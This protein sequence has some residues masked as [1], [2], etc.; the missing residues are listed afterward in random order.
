[1]EE[2]GLHLLGHRDRARG[3]G[4]SAAGA[5]PSATA[6][7]PRAR[8]LTFALAAPS[9]LQLGSAA[10]MGNAGVSG[11][12]MIPSAGHGPS[13][14]PLGSGAGYGQLLMSLGSSGLYGARAAM[15]P[16]TL[17]D[18]MGSAGDQLGQAFSKQ[19]KETN[20]EALREARARIAEELKNERAEAAE[21][22]AEADSKKR[23]Q[24][25][26]YR[27]ISDS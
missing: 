12:D 18:T 25:G 19:L 21:H 16:P 23:D 24:E 15:Y 7:G 5:A 17:V 9:G 27:S 11:R 3:T 22:Q 20:I 8:G 10:A 13:R 2:S 4:A 14:A 6:A 1:M 26:G